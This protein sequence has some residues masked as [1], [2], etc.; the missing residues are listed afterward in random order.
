VR[1]GDRRV[2]VHSQVDYDAISKI[3]LCGGPWSIAYAGLK[4]PMLMAEREH[5]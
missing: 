4:G 2:Q 5:Q 3:L 1:L